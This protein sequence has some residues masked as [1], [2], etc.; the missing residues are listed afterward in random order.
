MIHIQNVTT[1][2]ISSCQKHIFPYLFFSTSGFLLTLF[3]LN[4]NTKTLF[5]AFILLTLLHA[6]ILKNTKLAIFLSYLTTTVVLSGKSYAFQIIESQYVDTYI[7]PNG[8]S[9]F[10]TI[11]IGD[12]YIC[13]MLFMLFRYILIQK[14]KIFH[15]LTLP[16]VFLGLYIFCSF[17]SAVFFSQNQYLSLFYTLQTTGILITILYIT[18]IYKPS[19]YH[20]MPIFLGLLSFESIITL[21]QFF[22][23]SVIG[24]SLE[25][26]TE[27]T[28]QSSI[29]ED[30]FRTRPMGTFWHS[31]ELA[32]WIIPILFCSLGY[33]YIQ[34]NNKHIVLI[35]IT[36]LLGIAALL[37]TQSR[38]A[39]LS[40]LLLLLPFLYIIE[41][42]MNYHITVKSKIFLLFLILGI[43]FLIGTT[44]IIPE[45][46]IQTLNMFEQNASGWSRIEQI[47]EWGSLIIQYPLFG[48]G[49]GMSLPEVF[50]NKVRDKTD[51]LYYLPTV[52]HNVYLIVMSETGVISLLFLCGYFYTSIRNSILLLAV[53]KKYPTIMQLSCLFGIIAVAINYAFQPYNSLSQL[54]LISALLLSAQKIPA[55]K[56]K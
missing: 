10:I 26:L 46:L 20:Y 8:V 45:R 53:R 7:H 25:I 54:I 22:K 5:G 15:L 43:C 56:K 47:K 35:S 36:T 33:L 40:F 44:R 16:I 9:Q 37:V 17:I 38:S 6:I 2:I 28:A 13:I 31:N 39:W 32:N 1:S 55:V 24:S 18:I 21:I 52:V 27:M 23:N 48:V 12:I 49:E 14:K 41:R 4:Q 29:G 34:K 11:T 50:F 42:R 3:F 30:S 19:Q 51:V